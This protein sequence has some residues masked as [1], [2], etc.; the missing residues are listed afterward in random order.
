LIVSASAPGVNQASVWTEP[1]AGRL[2]NRIGRSSPNWL[3][4]IVAIER[5][6]A[7]WKPKQL[8]VVLALASCTTSCQAQR[9]LSPEGAARQAVIA[10]IKSVQQ[11]LGFE[12]TRNFLRQS[13]DT[14]A[15]YRCYYTQ[16][17]ELPGTYE[18]L[19]MR[20]GTRDGC[21]LDETKYDV[22]FYPIEAVASEAASQ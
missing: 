1:A 7:L 18:G 8:L 12:P 2:M 21:A 4:N 14:E 17:F 3:S 22:F 9:Q 20:E 16:K 5:W 15:V 13:E 11:A 10:E 19:R 6:S